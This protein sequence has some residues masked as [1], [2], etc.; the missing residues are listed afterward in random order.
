MTMKKMIG[1]QVNIEQR[2]I[3][4]IM[5]SDAFN[6]IAGSSVNSLLKSITFKKRQGVGGVHISLPSSAVDVIGGNCIK[7]LYSWMIK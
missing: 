1:R 2:L 5:Q 6:V 4:F 3:Y 7:K